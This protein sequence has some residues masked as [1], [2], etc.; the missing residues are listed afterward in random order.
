MTRRVA[1]VREYTNCCL[2][3]REDKMGR[4]LEWWIAQ[5]DKPDLV[6][7]FLGRCRRVDAS[8]TASHP[9]EGVPVIMEAPIAQFGQPDV[10]FVDEV[11]APSAGADTPQLFRCGRHPSIR[12]T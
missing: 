12:A 3:W 9:S 11:P 8:L 6:E 7:R 4:A 10:L 2:A 1:G 5:L